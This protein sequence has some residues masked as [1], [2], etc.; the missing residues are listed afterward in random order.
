MVWSHSKSGPLTSI[1]YMSY[2]LITY[3]ISL[4]ERAKNIL[5]HVCVLSNLQVWTIAQELSE[6]LM[7][8]RG[9]EH[10]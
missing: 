3:L 10:T 2:G 7:Q 1:W 9:K 5:S 6:L 8:G 4:N